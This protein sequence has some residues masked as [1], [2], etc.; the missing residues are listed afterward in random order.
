MAKAQGPFS[1][2]NFKVFVLKDDKSKSYGMPI[3]SQSR[4]MFIRELQEQLSSGQSVI[5]RHPQ[6]FGVFEIGEYDPRTGQVLLY[7]QKTHLGLAQDFRV[8][9]KSLS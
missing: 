6:D 4:G 2:Q 7:E 8:P 1:D 9:E 3:T 5:S